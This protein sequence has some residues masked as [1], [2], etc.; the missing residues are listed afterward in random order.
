LPRH[1]LLL[2][3][4]RSSPTC[5]HRLRH[6]RRLL[7]L[8][9]VI[10]LLFLLSIS[11]NAP[12]PECS[13]SR[14]Y[15]APYS[16]YQAYNNHENIVWAGAAT[17]PVRRSCYQAGR[18]GHYSCSLG[19]PCLCP[20]SSAQ[21]PAID[22]P[23]PHSVT[24][25]I[26]SVHGQHDITPE[27]GESWENSGWTA[28][29]T[30]ADAQQQRSAADLEW[31]A[32]VDDDA[33]AGA[34]AYREIHGEGR[35]RP[36]GY[37]HCGMRNAAT[38]H[39]RYADRGNQHE[40]FNNVRGRMTF[41]DWTQEEWDQ[42]ELMQHDPPVSAHNSSPCSLPLLESVSPSPPLQFR[43]PSPPPSPEPLQI[44][45]VPDGEAGPTYALQVGPSLQLQPLQQRLVLAAQLRHALISTEEEEM[46]DRNCRT[47][48]PSLPSP[49]PP[50]PPPATAVATTQFFGRRGCRPQSAPTVLKARRGSRSV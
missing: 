39:F 19:R 36:N 32:D 1:P 30:A 17:H 2:Y 50:P 25:G 31:D 22:P 45:Y 20:Q 41:G 37:A 23:L 6:H 16:Q 14:P 13:H 29:A 12:L 43:N 7:V 10:L 15:L 9:Y 28:G 21:F 26:Q 5:H 42:M 48:S 49:S 24:N 8:F 3:R 35:H 34:A 44:Q 40:R 4:K 47:V 18:V 27:E 46:L 33:Y 38:G 11:T